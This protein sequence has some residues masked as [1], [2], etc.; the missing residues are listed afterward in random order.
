MGEV[1]PRSVGSIFECEV[2]VR[3]GWANEGVE[4]VCVVVDDM[5]LDVGGE[6]RREEI[7]M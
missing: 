1:V 5:V 2:G 7:V 6:S 4:C 3:G